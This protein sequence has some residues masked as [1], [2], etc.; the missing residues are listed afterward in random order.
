MDIEVLN[1]QRCGAPL[2]IKSSLCECDYCS[3]INLIG[4]E[5]GKYI[6][7]LNRANKLRQECEFDRAFAVYDDILAENVP[8]V[9]VLWS[10]ALCE[11]GIEYVQDPVSSR[12]HP[13]LHRI[14][15]THF[16]YSRNYLDALEIANEEQKEQL[17]KDGEEIAKIQE[18][19]LNIA[20]NEN[21][22]D[23]FIC[24]KETDDE[25]K[26]RTEDSKLAEQL[27]EYLTGLGL[28][29]F[30]A[31]ITLREKL[32]VNYEPYIFAAIKSAKVMVVLGTKQEY[33]TAVWVKNEWSRFFKLKE[34][35]P[36]KLLLFACNDIEDLPRAFQRKQAQLLQEENAILNLAN[37]INNYIG[38]KGN[39]FVGGKNSKGIIS[40]KKRVVC[41]YC[42]K[43]QERN[44][45]GCIF[46]HRE[47]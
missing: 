47:I 19:Y 27:Y 25:T 40:T 1:C 33:F 31:R 23:V 24:Y 42:G 2:K 32:G 21:P 3:S 35:D 5:A 43:S 8:S 15:D 18:E 26:V 20:A 10:Q 7:Q 30:F 39:G 45:Y 37:N 12:Y 36:K 13:T 17:K 14:K 28:K 9:D 41:P 38:G 29:V 4:G 6:N 44:I 46:C 11:Y 22:Y 34:S 16:L